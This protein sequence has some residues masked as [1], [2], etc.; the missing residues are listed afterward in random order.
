[1]SLILYLNTFLSLN[2]YNLVW[3]WCYKTKYE[4]DIFYS[5]T[6]TYAQVVLV[7]KKKKKT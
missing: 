6:F 4:C 1:M 2:L 5:P 3:D 7:Q